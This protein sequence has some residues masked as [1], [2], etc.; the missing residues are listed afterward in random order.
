M[1]FSMM[2]VVII[3]VVEPLFSDLHRLTILADPK[4]TSSKDFVIVP[5]VFFVDVGFLLLKLLYFLSRAV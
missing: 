1:G 4:L 5:L 2:P 3:A